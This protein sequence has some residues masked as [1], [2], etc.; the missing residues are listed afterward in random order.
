MATHSSILA[1]R[2]PWTEEPAG[3]QFIGL[4]KVR[5]NLNR[6]IMHVHLVPYHIP[7]FTCK[8]E[9]WVMV[10]P[11]SFVCLFSEIIILCSSLSTSD[12]S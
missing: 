8:K 4:Q 12:K 2:I 6:L 7:V 3:L 1:W 11:I 5:P 10:K 9:T